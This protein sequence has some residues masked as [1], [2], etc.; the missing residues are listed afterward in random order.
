[1]SIGVDVD[2]QDVDVNIVEVDVVDV[3]KL[4]ENF[5]KFQ[6][7]FKAQFE[8]NLIRQIVESFHC[9]STSTS[10]TST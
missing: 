10:P 7:I 3:Q 6:K 2:I 9:L 4:F 8:P 1:M 5:A